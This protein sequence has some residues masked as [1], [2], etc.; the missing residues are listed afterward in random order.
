M[1]FCTYWT[2][3]SHEKSRKT[4]ISNTLRTQVDLLPKK[5][6]RLTDGWPHLWRPRHPGWS[7]TAFLYISLALMLSLTCAAGRAS[8]GFS[9]LQQPTT[10]NSQSRVLCSMMFYDVLWCSMMFYDVLWCSM[11]FYDVLWCS[12][13]FYDVLWLCDCLRVANTKLEECWGIGVASLRW[14]LTHSMLRW[15]ANNLRKFKDQDRVPDKGE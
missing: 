5:Q 12:M 3:K 13:M 10:R 14:Q 9:M 4:N 15:K 11:M 8:L 2:R 7:C 1:Q 6:K